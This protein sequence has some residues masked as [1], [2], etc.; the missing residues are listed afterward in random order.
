[1]DVI[2]SK[3]DT[4]QKQKINDLE[5]FIFLNR[6]QHYTIKVAIVFQKVLKVFDQRIKYFPNFKEVVYQI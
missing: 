5:S 1:M 6:Y 4:I 2:A 3:F